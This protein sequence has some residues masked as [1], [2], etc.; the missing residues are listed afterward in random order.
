MEY[1]MAAKAAVRRPDRSHYKLVSTGTL[2]LRSRFAQTKPHL[3]PFRSA[4]R[5][6]DVDH[7]F[8]IFTDGRWCR[9]TIFLGTALPV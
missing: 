4:F 9:A 1:A 6:G 7:E 5:I 8:A 2:A 3:I